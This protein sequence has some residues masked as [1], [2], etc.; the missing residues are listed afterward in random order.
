MS[1]NMMTDAELREEMTR[2]AYNR[3]IRYGVTMNALMGDTDTLPGYL[4]PEEMET[5][6]V[7][8]LNSSNVIRCLCTEVTTK[9]ERYLP[10]V[11]GKVSPS[12]YRKG[13]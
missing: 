1:E 12:G 13:L 8:G 10:I 4:L 9:N 5:K 3:Y 6:L 11:G 2:T 7:S